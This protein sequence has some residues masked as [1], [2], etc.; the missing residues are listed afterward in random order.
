MGISLSYI[1]YQTFNAVI[2]ALII[3][4]LL[5]WVPN[6]NWYKEP[7]YSIRAFSDF[8]FKPFRKFIPPIGAIDISPIFVFMLLG[9]LQK[10]L[11]GILIRIGL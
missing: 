6:I 1:V 10:V 9:I 5:T 4:V 2:V 3:S 8:F 11:V 7:F